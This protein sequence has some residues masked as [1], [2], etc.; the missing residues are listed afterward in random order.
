MCDP[1]VTFELIEENEMD[2]ERMAEIV[3]EQVNR[4]KPN[5]EERYLLR[6]QEIGD[7]FT[8]E[9]LEGIIGMS[10]A[11]EMDVREAFTTYFDERI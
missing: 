11:T 2:Y 7:D 6:I 5:Y 1:L 8:A 9:L 4:L 10:F 3:Q